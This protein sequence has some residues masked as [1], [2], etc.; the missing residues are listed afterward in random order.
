[1][2]FN[3]IGRFNILVIYFF[4]YVNEVGIIKFDFCFYNCFF[5]MLFCYVVLIIR[6]KKFMVCNN[7]LNIFNILKLCWFFCLCRLYWI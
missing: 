4:G 2:K 5:Y 1:M 3:L 6:K 7:E